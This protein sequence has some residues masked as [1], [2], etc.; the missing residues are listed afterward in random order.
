MIKLKRKSAENQSFDWRPNFRNYE[1]L[2]DLRAVRTQFFIPALS[3]CIAVVFTIFI[4]S[5]EYR[6]MN[7]SGD[8]EKLEEEIGSY[9]ERH[10]E[11]VKLNSEF[12]GI[13]RTL[14]EVSEFKA[15]RLVASDFMLAVTS[16]LLEG[17]YLNRIEYIEGRATVEGSVQVSA[18]QASRLVNEYLKSLEE[19]DVLQGLLTDYKLTSLER[20]TNGE[21]FNFRIVISRG[22]EE[23]K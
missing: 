3:I 14:D 9:E 11:K 6:A 2:P 23:V 19:G 1:E 4:V 5:Q 8:I 7:I 21:N 18:E 10:E 22:E 15:D 13:S 17:M 16:R 20:N 12:R